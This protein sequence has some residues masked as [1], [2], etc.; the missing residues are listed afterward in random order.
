MDIPP[1]LLYYPL[2][3]LVVLAIPAAYRY[4]SRTVSA[5]FLTNWS[6]V[7][8]PA[9]IWIGFGLPCARFRA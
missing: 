8:K 3:S 6:S 5:H 2:T 7:L 9:R 1:A 4:N